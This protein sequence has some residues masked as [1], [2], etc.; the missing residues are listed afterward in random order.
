[1]RHPQLLKSNDQD[2]Q[3]QF[4]YVE[5]GNRPLVFDVIGPFAIQFEEGK[6]GKEGRAIICAPL[7]FDH[8]ANLL[9][10]C[11][12]VSVNGQTSDEGGLVYRFTE[13][14]APKGAVRFP[15]P[16][17]RDIFRVKYK[18]AK[19]PG[20]IDP[21]DIADYCHLVFE[22]PM[23]NRIEALRPEL[24]WVHRN[25]SDVWVIDE[26]R[27]PT[28]ECSKPE[29]DKIVNSKRGRGLRL[30][31]NECCEPPDFDLPQ[32]P[33]TLP[34]GLTAAT[35]GFPVG[36]GDLIPAYYSITLRFAASHATGDGVDDA[37]SCFETMRRMLDSYGKVKYFSQWRAD[38]T[39]P[40]V[41]LVVATVGGPHPRDC[42]AMV[43]VM[44][45]WSDPK[46][47]K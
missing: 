25:G 11:D 21:D 23:P 34:A 27:E 26:D 28:S 1:M 45:D 9:T 36:K 42:G 47:Q 22:V 19:S 12:D 37:H 24:S 30:I 10:D 29:P 44:Q 31:Y 20:G 8:H 14:Q 38:F 5:L 39:E 16:T 6:S 2:D 35:R 15:R 18:A 43:L 33:K 40:S 3:P 17:G 32:G 4:D 13:G 41:D 46:D 7:C